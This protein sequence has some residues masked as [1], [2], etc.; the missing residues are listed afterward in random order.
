MA[1]KTNKPICPSDPSPSSADK[2]FSIWADQEQERR[3]KEDDEAFEKWV[4]KREPGDEGPG[5]AN[6]SNT[7]T[8]GKEMD[9]R[10]A[11]N[12]VVE[13][14]D[15]RDVASDSV[16]SEPL[17]SCDGFTLTEATAAEKSLYQTFYAAIKAF[18]TAEEQDD[19][20]RKHRRDVYDIF[21]TAKD[22]VYRDDLRGQ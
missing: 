10:K 12:E 16:C 15:A 4:Q 7:T 3:A 9:V 8:E 20:Q 22:D 1:W 17:T 6:P 13:G 18:T 19:G 2:D 14:K 11:I 21:H 5:I